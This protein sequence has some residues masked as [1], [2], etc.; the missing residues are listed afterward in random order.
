PHHDWESG[1]IDEAAILYLA[2]KCVRED[3]RVTL[4]E[5]FAGSA[6]RCASPEAKAAHAARLGTA[7]WLRDEINGIC[8][9]TVIE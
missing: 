5:R 2:D 3:R 1:P 8:G 4:E 9:K 6:A 7:L